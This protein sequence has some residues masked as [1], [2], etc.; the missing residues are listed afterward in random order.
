MEY[1]DLTILLTLKGRHFHTL[2]WIWHANHIHLPFHIVVADGEVN[3]IVANLLDNSSNF[4][5]L[6]YD[7]QRYLDGSF[8][9]FYAKCSDAIRKV[10]TPFVMMSDNDDFPMPSGILR[11]IGFLRQEREYVCSS[12]AV[13]GFGINSDGKGIQPNVVGK[14]NNL[15]FNFLDTYSFGNVNHQSVIDRIKFAAKKSSILY[16]H[17]FRTEAL[18][19]VFDEIRELDFSDLQIHETFIAFRA[20]TLG[21]AHLD[22]TCV[23]YIRQI[24]T[25]TPYHF[26]TNW[27]SHL[28]RSRFTS[29]FSA[30]VSY[31][32]EESGIVD[33]FARRSFREAIIESYTAF[34]TSQLCDFYGT[35]KNNERL[36]A[37]ARKILPSGFLEFRSRGYKSVNRQRRTILARLKQEG[38]SE[39]YLNS[40]RME[41]TQIEETLEG[42][43]FLDFLHSAVGKDLSVLY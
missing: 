22:E 34:L 35:S 43:D 9:D 25:S 27:A 7:Y 39:G 38:A 33:E 32:C 20:L 29:D 16:Y 3:P 2:R 5:N 28:L 8:S 24:G 36:K 1:K 30:M 19:L 23:S 13:A 41:L 4:P 17:V 26:R 37:L 42:R 40:F 15:L 14:L 18:R 31:V 10:R 21:K 6:S 11:A 12:G